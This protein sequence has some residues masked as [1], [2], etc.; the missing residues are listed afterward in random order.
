MSTRTL[1]PVFL[2]ASLLAACSSGGGEDDPD[3][4]ACCNLDSPSCDCFDPTGAWDPVPGPIQD[5]ARDT[6]FT[7]EACVANGGK[8]YYQMRLGLNSRP[9]AQLFAC[10]LVDLAPWIPSELGERE[11]WCSEAIS[12]WHREAGLPY[13]S[14]SR[15]GDW[16]LD[17]QRTNTGQMRTFYEV[18][19]DSGGRGRWIHWSDLDYEDHQPGVNAPLPGS[20]VLLRVYDDTVTPGVWN[21]FSHSIM[22]DELTVYRT[23]D[24][25]VDRMEATILEGNSGGQV[26][27][28]R[29]IPDLLDVTPW[30]TQFLP[31]SRKILGFGVDL[32]ASGE[33]IY[34]ETRLHHVLVGSGRTMPARPP[35]PS[36]LIWKSWYGPL[37]D[38][39]VAFARAVRDKGGPLVLPS[40]Q[41]LPFDQ[42]PDGNGRRWLIPENV[43]ELA[44]QGFEV[45][46]DLHGVHPVPVLR[47]LL[48]WSGTELP[49][50]YR[51]LYAG[52]NQEYVDAV[53]PAIPA[54]AMTFGQDGMA[55]MPVPVSLG[56]A[57]ANIR[58]LR[59]LFP[60]GSLAGVRALEDRRLVHD[61]GPDQ[62]AEENP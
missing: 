44:P 39:L 6:L 31:S 19:E 55:A 52:E 3:D 15:N 13:P 46:I 14:G 54:G 51:V 27:D 18:E 59:L 21:G 35:D 34:D 29:V 24:G 12:Y 50:G 7:T 10:A 20:Y 43:D 41:M 22:I 61:P 8:P 11:A 25:A 9:S 53:V 33:P 16:V 2:V 49:Q 60:A 26:I 1:L 23:S 57:G 62:A 42:V 38:P 32:D 30:G 47:V 28:T 58:S 45:L 36:D 56:T 5:V 4:P 37:I 17:W 48:H 40:T